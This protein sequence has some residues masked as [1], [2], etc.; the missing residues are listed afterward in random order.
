M[1][2]RAKR[3]NDIKGVT[4][5]YHKPWTIIDNKSQKKQ[6]RPHFEREKS[7]N[8]FRFAI[9]PIAAHNWFLV[10]AL[11]GATLASPLYRNGIF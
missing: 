2:L 11:L 5:N 1:S 8:L 10:I 7:K 9:N 6:K 4:N 3:G